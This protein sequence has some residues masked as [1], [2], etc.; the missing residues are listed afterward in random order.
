MYLDL[1]EDFEKIAFSRLAY[2]LIAYHGIE[3][4]EEKL[5]YAALA[6]MGIGVPDLEDEVDIH[7]ECQAFMSLQSKRIA[8]VELMVL[9]LADGDLENEEQSL[10]DDIIGAFGFDADTLQQAWQW[11]HGWYVT[12]RVGK[13][14]VQHG[15]LVAVI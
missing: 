3:E 14:F 6:E 5:Y 13:D 7:L 4:H 11:V 12:Y 8:L 10:L 1:L 15:A 2:R 9:A